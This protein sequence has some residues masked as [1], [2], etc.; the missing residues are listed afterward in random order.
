M[1][2]AIRYAR[3]TGTP[4]FGICLGMQM[5]TIEFARHVCGIEDASSTEFDPDAEN[6]VI[7]LMPD[8]VGVLAKGGTMRLG[9]YPC[10]LHEGT[11]A[12]HIYDAE[13]VSERHRHR[14]EVN[15]A[16]REVL[17]EHGMVFS[18]TSPDERLVE[19]I[20]LPDHPWFIGCQFHPD[21][22][23]RPTRPHPLFRDFVRAA[24]EHRERRGAEGSPRHESA[25]REEEEV[26][27]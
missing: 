18:G 27:T 4:F 25:V 19:M 7:A 22:K 20:E 26:A 16:F 9:A 6:P 3:E 24:V 8:Q 10:R 17:A 14:Y 5:A 1:I 23:S 12:R 21:V 15:N 2:E 11:L 13:E